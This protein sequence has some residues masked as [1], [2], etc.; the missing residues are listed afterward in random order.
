[1]VFLTFAVG[2]VS[3]LVRS[4]PPWC[5]C[6]FSFRSDFPRKSGGAT[7]CFCNFWRNFGRVYLCFSVFFSLVKCFRVA[8]FPSESLALFCLFVYVFVVLAVCLTLLFI[9]SVLSWVL[10]LYFVFSVSAFSLL[11]VAL[12]LLAPFVSSWLHFSF[13]TR[14]FQV[15]RFWLRPFLTR[16]RSLC[17]LLPSVLVRFLL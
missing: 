10:W 2:A 6:R 8:S 7:R 13:L 16:V 5:G 14:P 12:F 17:G 9:G 4:R 1:M 15:G 11:G 3:L